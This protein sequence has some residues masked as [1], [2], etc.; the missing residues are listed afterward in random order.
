MM[1]AQAAASQDASVASCAA[2]A[3]YIA[4]SV[5]GAVAADGGLRGELQGCAAAGLAANC[6]ACAALGNLDSL[7]AG[8]VDR[9]AAEEGDAL[10]TEDSRSADMMA[11]E[12]LRVECKCNG[13][14]DGGTS[15]ETFIASQD[16]QL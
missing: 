9:V 2:A 6:D 10:R 7:G 3:G 16:H 5:D 4:G 15:R 8:V 1:A 12:S 11:M 13:P 14:G